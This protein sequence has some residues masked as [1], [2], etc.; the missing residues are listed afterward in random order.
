MTCELHKAVSQ[1]LTSCKR[2]GLRATRLACPICSTETLA[3]RTMP[4]SSV[5]DKVQAVELFTK[6]GAPPSF[7]LLG[8]RENWQG[9]VDLGNVHAMHFQFMFH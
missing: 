7:Y 8:L 6:C 2:L 4:E 1:T 3:E 9:A 5:L